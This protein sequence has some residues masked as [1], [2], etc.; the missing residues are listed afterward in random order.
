MQEQY[1]TH[2][3]ITFHR[4]SAFKQVVYNFQ[5]LLF[6]CQSEHRHSLA[7]PRQLSNQS[8]ELG[9]S[10]TNMHISLF[11]GRVNCPN[12][13]CVRSYLVAEHVPLDVF[14]FVRAPQRHVDHDRGDEVHQRQRTQRDEEREKERHQ[15]RRRRAVRDDAAG[16]AL[17]IV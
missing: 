2:E 5:H 11:Q 9:A 10:H 4:G 1:R 6:V 16:H 15:P 14:F 3:V 8:V 13:T 17:P 12:R 7:R